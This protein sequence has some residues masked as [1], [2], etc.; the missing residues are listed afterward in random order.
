MD[1]KRKNGAVLLVAGLS[2]APALIV[3]SINAPKPPTIF[4]EAKHM[5]FPKM[6]LPKTHQ[7]IDLPPVIIV[8]DL[9]EK[10]THT[11]PKALV[12]KG[13][14]DLVQGSGSVRTCEWE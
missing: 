11:K 13:E 12:C 4:Q 8:A 2:F 3:G 7:Q 1:Q 6:E 14:R 5:P 9:P 10:V